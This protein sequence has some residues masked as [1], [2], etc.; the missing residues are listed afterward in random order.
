M[1]KRKRRITEYI[2]LGIGLAIAI[3]VMA[4]VTLPIVNST[5][6]YNG[7][8]SYWSG[9]VLTLLSNSMILVAVLPL[10]VVAA[11]IMLVFR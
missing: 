4:S 11:A 5:I 7:T 10:A 1:K 2:G 8:D 9:S 6:Y 3:L